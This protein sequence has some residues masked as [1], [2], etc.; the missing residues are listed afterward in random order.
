MTMI[1]KYNACLKDRQ[2]IEEEEMR[3]NGGRKVA[4]LKGR[5]TFYDENQL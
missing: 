5:C 4:L 1:E 3:N 2:R